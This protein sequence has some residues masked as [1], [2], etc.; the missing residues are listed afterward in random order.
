[1]SDMREGIFGEYPFG[2]AA[3]RK[4]GDTPANFLLFFAGWMGDLKTTD[5]MK[6]TG[7]VFR[8]AKKGKDKGKLCIKVPGTERTVYVTKA[9]M[10]EFSEEGEA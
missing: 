3:L 10:A 4:M 2:K 9:E 6:V 8:E 5:T 7:A 1:M